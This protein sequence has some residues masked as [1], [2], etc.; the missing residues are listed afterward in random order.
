VSEFVLP[1]RYYRHHTDPGVPCVEA[2]FQYAQHT[3]RIPT[4]QAALILVDVWDVHPVASHLARTDEITRT[5]IV[6]V[7]EAARKAGVTVIHAPSLPIA[8]KYPQWVRYAEDVD[9]QSSP[10]G[11]RWP[12]PTFARREGDYAQFA[13]PAEPMMDLWQDRL[14]ARRILADVEPEA[15]DFVVGTGEQLQRLL[16]DRQI[17]HL[18]YVGFATN[19]CVPFRDYGMRAFRKRGYN[20]ILLR[21]CTTAIEAHDTVDD[22]LI[23]RLAIRDFEMMD[24]AWT[25]TGEDFLRVCG[26]RRP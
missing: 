22:L 13:R 12:P 8:K 21:D 14:A 3:L 10:T 11:E 20:P 2:N 9:P 1:V 5:R 18:F 15:D 17:L 25:A 19:I 7:V 23:T 24:I 6:P 16:A 4:D 26:Q